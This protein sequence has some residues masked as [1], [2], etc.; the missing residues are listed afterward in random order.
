MKVSGTKVRGSL[1]INTIYGTKVRE[2][3]TSV[4]E[5]T[6]PN[7]SLTLK[8]QGYCF[9]VPT[10]ETFS[11]FNGNFWSRDVKSCSPVQG[12]I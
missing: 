12:R 4:G 1:K 5:M 6:D 9:D 11:H 10:K 8:I 3:S 7:S 2:F